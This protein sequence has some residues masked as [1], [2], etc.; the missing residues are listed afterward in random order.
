M[1]KQM[2]ETSREIYFNIFFDVDPLM[3]YL[4]RCN[5]YIWWV[6]Q[7]IIFH[8]SFYQF[9]LIWCD[10]SFMVWESLLM[11]CGKKYILHVVKC[12]IISIIRNTLLA[13]CAL[14]KYINTPFFIYCFAL[15]SLIYTLLYSCI[16][17][18][19]IVIM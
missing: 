14:C 19:F 8:F 3:I 18:F 4:N 15:L 5:I 9:Y 6:W 17:V 13:R 12:L 11:K 10:L 2:N 1:N 7:I 16:Y